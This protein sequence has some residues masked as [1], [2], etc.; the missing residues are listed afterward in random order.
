MSNND[1]LNEQVFL[2][3]IEKVAEA[4]SSPSLK[5]QVRLAP[6][7]HSVKQ[8][9]IDNMSITLHFSANN[10]TIATLTATRGPAQTNRPR[11][12]LDVSIKYTP[13][14]SSIELSPRLKG[15]TMTPIGIPRDHVRA[16]EESLV[17][18]NVIRTSVPFAVA[19]EA[20][21]EKVRGFSSQFF[22]TASSSYSSK[23]ID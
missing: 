20:L 9:G 11:P 13:V 7:I 19:V 3:L 10:G 17:L 2:D 15:P 12:S 16:M 5:L 6:F 18:T 21:Y 4:A 1:Q 14:L 22:W 8:D 23:D